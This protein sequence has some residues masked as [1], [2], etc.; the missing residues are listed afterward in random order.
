MKKRR[1]MLQ[2]IVVL[3]ATGVALWLAFQPAVANHFDY[4]LPVRNGLPC[5]IHFDGRDYDNNEQCAGISRSSWQVWYD[6][7]NHVPSGGSCE[8]LSALR[9]EQALPLREV[10]GISTFLGSGHL[11][12][13]PR[14]VNLH[15]FT[16]TVLFVTDGA[17]YRAYALSG[18]P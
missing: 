1:I 4:A 3:I 10:G 11:L 9:S 2:G 6:A 7:R 18:G 14:R 13:V 16:P 8:S 17:C 12:M 5:R 15:R